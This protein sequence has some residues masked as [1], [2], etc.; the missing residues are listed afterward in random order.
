MTHISFWD[1]AQIGKLNRARTRVQAL[2][3]NHTKCLMVCTLLN[4]ILTH[5]N[6]NSSQA[7]PRLGVGN[8]WG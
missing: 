7:T 2:S 3:H 4:T 5:A 6:C 8:S 1:Y